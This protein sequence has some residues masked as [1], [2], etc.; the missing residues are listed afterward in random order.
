MGQE[1][2]V[3]V[4]RY[5]CFDTI[6]ERIHRKLQEKRDLFRDVVDDV[7][8]NL[9]TALTEQ[10]LFGL[11]GLQAPRKQQS[12]VAESD[13]PDFGS[14]SGVE[15]EDW[16]GERLESHGFRVSRTPLSHDG[17]VDLLASRCDHLGI[18]STLHVQCKNTN[19]PVGVGTVRE[20]RGVVPDR[21]S[22]VTPIV[23]C[24]S[25]FT[26]DAIAF[27][28]QSGVLLWDMD[29]LKNLAAGDVSLCT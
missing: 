21:S 5:I 28:V 14:L 26:S 10:E 19:T 13:I 15:F 22:G 6:E 17:G 16:V 27:A 4:Y 24:P 12:A 8:L 29:A 20:L 23:A 1:Q 18:E 9:G 25:G 11:F 2:A 3:T 7:T